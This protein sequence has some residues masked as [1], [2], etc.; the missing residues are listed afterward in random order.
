ML[1]EIMM[2]RQRLGAG[3][4]IAT[5][6]LENVRIARAGDWLSGHHPDKGAHLIA[7]LSI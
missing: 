5:G 2:E 4:R 6:E 3:F 7:A 1:Q